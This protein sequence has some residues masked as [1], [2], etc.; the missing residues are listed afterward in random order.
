MPS[1]RR[2]RFPRMFW[3]RDRHSVEDEF[4]HH[5]AMREG[6]L[7]SQGLPPDEARAQARRE[8]GNADD[9]RAYCEDVD[10]ARVQR[11]R[12]SLWA[13]EAGH[14][15]RHAIRQI[16]R[17]RGFAM[18]S[19]SVLALGLALFISALGVA[20][21]YLMRGLPFP[22][23]DR[24]VMTRIGPTAEFPRNVPDLRNVD[25]RVPA[26]EFDGVVAWDLD[27]FTIM[28]GEH[29]EFADGAWVSPGYFDVLGV[30]PSLGRAFDSSEYAGTA[31]VAVISDGLW[32]RRFGA[33]PQV[34]GT[35]VRM[36][37]IDRPAEQELVTIVGVLPPD[38]WHVNR[39][40]E[41]IRPLTS[42]RQF[43]LAR[44]KAG[45]TL[46][47][48]Q[49]RLNAA[50]LPQVPS[51]DSTWSMSLVSLHD[52]YVMQARPAILALIGGALLTLLIVIT[53]AA[54]MSAVRSAK[55][56]GEFAVRAALG[57]GRARIARQAVAESLVLTGFAAVIGT[58]V[59]RILM[60]VAG[61]AIELRLGISVPGGGS[62]LQFDWRIVALVS[63]TVL[64]AAM[65]TAWRAIRVHRAALNVSLRP[66]QSPGFEKTRFRNVVMGAQIAF[67]F[68]LLTGAALMG[69]SAW[70][71][72][73][74]PLGFEHRDVFL[75]AVLLPRSR[76]ADDT[77]RLKATDEMIAAAG[78]RPDVAMAA[79]AWPPPFFGGAPVVVHGEREGATSNVTRRTWVS[80]DYFKLLDIRQ[81][82]GRAFTLADVITAEPVAVVGER[83]ARLLWPSGGA[84][85]SRIRVGSDAG[86]P[87]RRV[88]GIVE[89]TKASAESVQPAEIYL[90][91]SQNPV[92]FVATIVKWK[93]GVAGNIN[94]LRKALGSVDET[95]ALT[96]ARTL[97]SMVEQSTQRPR[98][99]SLLLVVFSVFGLLLSAVGLASA[100]AHG[101]AQ[102]RPELAVRLA[103]GA[104]PLQIFSMI[105]RDASVLVG[106]S[107]AAGAVLSIAVARALAGQLYG[108]SAADPST[109]AAIASLV[110]VVA[111]VA[112]VVPA[113]RAA[114]V[115]P[116]RTLRAG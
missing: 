20:D 18:S 90:P 10:A 74:E 88:V 84:I 71:M 87:W 82:D 80:A 8:F 83:L 78:A 96:N 17:H 111:L 65:L 11:S 63:L 67:T 106:T 68:A 47:R 21:A 73:H 50:V 12:A 70:N 62:L 86:A 76:F 36:F 49:D 23:A 2:F 54:G 81:I 98:S 99:L 45:M 35:S 13:D 46:P 44:M 92:S 107:I 29:P 19:I 60:G 57:A 100:L 103:L 34:V 52:D 16:A 38:A 6:A 77:S 37:S 58:G 33:D 9:A 95:L 22:D 75:G 39:F 113:R 105:V 25:W 94:E 114:T 42:P 97:T 14:D 108:V 79:S 53:N 66:G 101:V 55:R 109:Y 85:G 59:A 112:A 43:T 91:L 26:R 5:L 41:V 64:I 102:R 72:T 7:I 1:P 24:I 32:K 110:A 28:G 40:T 31:R 93:P 56:H 30:R 3:L 116:A 89:D 15:V 27:G 48:A 104:S 115:D 4:A 61:P 51:R 69:R